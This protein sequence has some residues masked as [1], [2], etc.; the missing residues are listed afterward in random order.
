MNLRYT[1]S[2]FTALFCI[3]MISCSESGSNVKTSDK[4]LDGIQKAKNTI[5]IDGQF[6]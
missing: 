2:I 4:K 1:S 3:L 5:Q 6:F